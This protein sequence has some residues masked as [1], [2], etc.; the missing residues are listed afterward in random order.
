MQLRTYLSNEDSFFVSQLP[1]KI[2][3]HDMLV[4]V[5]NMCTSPEQL[6]QLKGA[7]ISDALRV[8]D[9]TSENWT[10]LIDIFEIIENL[11]E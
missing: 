4:L 9:S 5:I 2:K 11:K 1:V 3:L 6:S 7:T 8:P 10:I